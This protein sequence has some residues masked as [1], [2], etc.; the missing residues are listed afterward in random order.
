[1]EAGER[2]L[3]DQQ[4]PEIAPKIN[5]L[6]HS[7]NPK[8]MRQQLDAR[9]AVQ[10]E[11]AAVPNLELLPVQLEARPVPRTEPHQTVPR[12]TINCHLQSGFPLSWDGHLNCHLVISG[13]LPV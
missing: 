10:T 8:A 13:Y 5:L 1:M 11:I 7:F 4:G 9:R 3:A 12:R 2:A 6:F